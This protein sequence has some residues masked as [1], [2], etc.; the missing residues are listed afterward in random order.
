MSRTR[1][2]FLNV[3]SMGRKVQMQAVTAQ[4]ASS[5]FVCV[6]QILHP[7]AH[8]PC[9][10]RKKMSGPFK[11]LPCVNWEGTQGVNAGRRSAQTQAVYLS[12]EL[13]VL[14]LL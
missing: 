2:R 7:R 14:S 10:V 4:R 3:L 8:V 5:V 12:S 11:G 6:K 9:P 1:T 13:W